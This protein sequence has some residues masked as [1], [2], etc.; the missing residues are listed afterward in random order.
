MATTEKAR[1]RSVTV[2]L[3]HKMHIYTVCSCTLD[4]LCDSC[5]LTIQELQNLLR[6]YHKCTVDEAAK[7]AAFIF[8]VR[9]KG[10]KSKLQSKLQNIP[11]VFA[12]CSVITFTLLRSD[13]K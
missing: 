13:H 6:G 11:Y 2:S 8:R 5:Y 9:F 10:D 4:S 1:S 7:L 12:F 3:S